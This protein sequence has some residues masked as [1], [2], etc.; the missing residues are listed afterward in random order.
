MH[1]IVADVVSIRIS[2]WSG[3]NANDKYTRIKNIF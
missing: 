2:R 3:N 1:P